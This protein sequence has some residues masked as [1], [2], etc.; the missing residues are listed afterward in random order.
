MEMTAI[1]RAQIARALATLERRPEY[2]HDKALIR[3]IA[4][5]EVMTE[6]VRKERELTAAR[7]HG[8]EVAA[9]SVDAQAYW[10][11]VLDAIRLG[12]LAQSSGDRRLE[13]RVSLQSERLEER[14]DERV[15]D[16]D[17]PKF[18]RSE[19]DEKTWD[20]RWS[21]IEFRPP[22]LRREY[23]GSGIVEHPAN[24]AQRLVLADLIDQELAKPDVAQA[25]ARAMS[26][27]RIARA[28]E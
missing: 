7:T 4:G 17:K 9:L 12:Q 22:L 11:D 18:L 26:L 14:F 6:I 27:I 23:L 15:P 25:Y 1:Q 5:R 3:R 21:F 28:S 13:K 10:D 16:C 20:E 19:G 8:K 2:A 24:A